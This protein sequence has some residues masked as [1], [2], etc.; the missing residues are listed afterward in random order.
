LGGRRA[1]PLSTDKVVETPREFGITQEAADGYG[2]DRAREFSVAG[3]AADGDVADGEA[4][5]N[6]LEKTSG[7]TPSGHAHFDLDG[8]G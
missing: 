5:G 8:A 7:D 3:K 1:A 2:A 4:R 6:S